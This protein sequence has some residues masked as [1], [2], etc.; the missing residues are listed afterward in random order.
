MLFLSGTGWWVLQR[1]LP[2]ET[3]FGL[4]S[5]PAQHG[6]ILLHGSAA[7][8]ALLLIGTLVPLHMKRGWH[9]QLN[10]PNGIMLV[11][12]VALLSLTGYGLYYAGG[13]ALRAAASLVHLGLGLAFPAA[14]LWHIVRGR[15]A[16]RLRPDSSS[17]RERRPPRAGQ[18]KTV[19]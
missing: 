8:L 6:M 15:R 5:H 18:H 9:T 11:S 7:M 19:R 12:L 17:G 10:R 3:E 1:W 16:R 2:V 14:L 13:E 4:Q